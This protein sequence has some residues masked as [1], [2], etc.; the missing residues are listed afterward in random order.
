MVL[1]PAGGTQLQI[2]VAARGLVG[3][4]FSTGLFTIGMPSRGIYAQI[5]RQLLLQHRH[6]AGV[7]VDLV[8]GPEGC[9]RR[10]LGFL[11]A[12]P[13]RP[14]CSPSSSAI[15]TFVV[16]GTGLVA[17]FAY[18]PSQGLGQVDV[19]FV[20]GVGIDLSIVVVATGAVDIVVL[21]GKFLFRGLLLIG[22]SIIGILALLLLVFGRLVV[23]VVVVVAR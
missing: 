23:V 7:R 17:G 16:R 8:L 19:G 11:L 18:H 1:D 9:R 2:V 14:S 10:R 6:G 3:G 12:P 5:Y 15:G 4:K 22:I 21:G 20:V 13:S